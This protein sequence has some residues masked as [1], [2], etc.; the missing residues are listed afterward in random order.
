MIKNDMEVSS[1]TELFRGA[2]KGGNVY[3]FYNSNW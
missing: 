1:F 3:F 2:A